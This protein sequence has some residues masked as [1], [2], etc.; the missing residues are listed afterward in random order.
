MLRLMIEWLRG[1]WQQLADELG[2]NNNTIK[3]I[4]DVCRNIALVKCHNRNPAIPFAEFAEVIF[5]HM[6][7]VL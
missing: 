5:R 7:M 4:R 3:Y 6:R 2:V 1:L